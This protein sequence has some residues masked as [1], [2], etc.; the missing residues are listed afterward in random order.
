MLCVWPCRYRVRWPCFGVVGSVARGPQLAQPPLGGAWLPV[1][2][3]AG[4]R[5]RGVVDP[6]F[7]DEVPPRGLLRAGGRVPPRGRPPPHISSRA[8]VGVAA[9]RAAL[10]GPPTFRAAQV[11]GAGLGPRS[12]HAGA[13]ISATGPSRSTPELIHTVEYALS[14]DKRLSEYLSLVPPDVDRAPAIS[15]RSRH[16]A[17]EI[18]ALARGAGSR[19]NQ[20]ALSSR[21][22]EGSAINPRR[23]R[24]RGARARIVARW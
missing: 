12:A 17:L 4:R 1:S 11:P 5:R 6:E 19:A 8:E 24:R 23:V 13:Q 3:P 21:A 16:L 22:G 14:K 18:C 15:A 9:S 2:L 10:A 7:G 20:C